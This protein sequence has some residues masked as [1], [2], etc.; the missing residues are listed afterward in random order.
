MRVAPN[1]PVL[2]GWPDGRQLGLAQPATNKK[3]AGYKRGG[4]D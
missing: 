2:L 4:E 1:L 3:P